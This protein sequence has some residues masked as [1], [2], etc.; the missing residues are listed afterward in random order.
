[1]PIEETYFCTFSSAVSLQLAPSTWQAFHDA[2]ARVAPRMSAI[3]FAFSASLRLPDEAPP[4]FVA[5]SG[6]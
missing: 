3:T 2:E 5:A 4:A 6:N 1:M